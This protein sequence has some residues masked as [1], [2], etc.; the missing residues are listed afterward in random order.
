[1]PRQNFNNPLV[2]CVWF[3]FQER[4]RSH[5]DAGCA[6]AT[7][8][9]V[10]ILKGLLQRGKLLA[11]SQALNSSNSPAVNLNRQK[12]TGAYGGII[13]NHGAST[14]DTVFATNVRPG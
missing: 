4:L 11:R 5:Q 9:C 3:A 14:A 1:M 10:I 13:Y 6:E 7:L 12:Q 8:K 2:I